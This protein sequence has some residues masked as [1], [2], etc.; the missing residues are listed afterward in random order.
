MR[1]FAGLPI[2]VP[3][4]YGRLA[5]PD[6]RFQVK[7]RLTRLKLSALIPL[8][9]VHLLRGSA[10]LRAWLGSHGKRDN[11]AILARQGVQP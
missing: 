1:I 10:F 6:K 5:E 9:E 8:V 2:A 4:P 7:I 3:T 11:C